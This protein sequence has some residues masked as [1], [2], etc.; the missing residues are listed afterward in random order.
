M[1]KYLYFV[2]VDEN[3]QQRLY[4]NLSQSSSPIVGNQNN[5]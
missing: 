4:T 5:Y 3:D 2:H 1:Q